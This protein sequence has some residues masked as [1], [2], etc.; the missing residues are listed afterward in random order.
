MMKCLYAYIQNQI[1][2]GVKKE[3]CVIY[4]LRLRLYLKKDSR[5]FL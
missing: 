2:D 1:K 5:H 4:P 3:K